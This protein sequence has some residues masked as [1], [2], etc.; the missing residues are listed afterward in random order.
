MLFEIF[1]DIDECSESAV[2]GD[3]AVCENVI[4]GFHCFCREGYQTPTGKAPFMPN[5]GSYCQ[6]DL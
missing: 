4:G 1:A 2:C 6:G 3:H 5:D